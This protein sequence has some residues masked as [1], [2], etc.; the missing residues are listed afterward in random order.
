MTK[1]SALLFGTVLLMVVLPGCASRKAM[2]PAPAQKE[3]F[4]TLY[5]RAEN[6]I[7]TNQFEKADAVV[8]TLEKKAKT[9]SEKAAFL[10]ARGRLN[11]ARNDLGSAAADLESSISLE[12]KNAETLRSLAQIYLAQH[13]AGDALSVLD[14]FLE[15]DSLD[16]SSKLVWSRSMALALGLEYLPPEYFD[17]VR[18]NAINRGELAAILI[19][20]AKRA[21]FD[22]KTPPLS[23]PGNPKVIDLRQAKGVIFPDTHRDTAGGGDTAFRA[24]T[25]QGTVSRVRFRDCELSWYAPYVERVVDAGF[26]AA[27]PDGSFRP[28]DRVTKGI[29]SLNVY[30]F[31]DRHCTTALADIRSALAAAA[32][33]GE[34]GS[35]QVSDPYQA[36]AAAYSD[37]GTGS[38]VWRPVKAVTALGIMSPSSPGFFGIDEPVSGNEAR[39]IA[40]NLAA[41]LARSNCGLEP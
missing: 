7:S 23:Q 20:E 17:A 33:N 40:S 37:V 24:P 35:A 8:K 27:F 41:L 30:S 14:R 12:P 6:L 39:T 38:Y 25:Y 1:S 10:G 5:V 9:D 31:L 15:F 22:L 18:S 4:Q 19:V 28:A 32:A 2:G 11:L 36:L 3:D 16:A 34:G 29:L 21:S 13:R 26:L